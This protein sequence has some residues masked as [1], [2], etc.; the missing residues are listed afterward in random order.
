MISAFGFDNLTCMRVLVLLRCTRL[1][2]TL[3]RRSGGFAGLEAA[4]GIQD[5]D[6]VLQALVV[7]AQKRSQFSLKFDLL[8]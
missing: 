2:S 6:D 4:L 5:R 3:A 7:L 8:L 1:T